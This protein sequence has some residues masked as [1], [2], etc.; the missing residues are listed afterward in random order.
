MRELAELTEAK[1]P[2]WQCDYDDLRGIEREGEF[3]AAVPAL[4][5][6]EDKE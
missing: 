2:G 6:T 4:G 5:T 3:V 1:A